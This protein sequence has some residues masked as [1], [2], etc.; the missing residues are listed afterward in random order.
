VT[1]TG[2]DWVGESNTFSVRS[3]VHVTISSERKAP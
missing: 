1:G 3:N 2:A